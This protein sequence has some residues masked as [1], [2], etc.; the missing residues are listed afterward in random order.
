MEEGETKWSGGMEAKWV[1]PFPI[2]LFF[3]YN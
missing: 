1:T 3:K 2:C